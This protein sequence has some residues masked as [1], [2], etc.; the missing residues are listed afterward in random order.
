MNKKQLFKIILILLIIIFLLTIF[1]INISSRKSSK[2]YLKYITSDE[3]DENTTSPKMIHYVLSAY[4]GVVNPKALSKSTYYIINQKI[5]EYLKYCK[6]NKDI[7]KYFEKNEND[8]YLDLGIDDKEQF[9]KFMDEINKLS[10]DLKY[11]SSRF[12]K[13]YTSIESDYTE[14]VIHIKYENQEEISLDMIIKNY[15][16]QDEPV[17]VYFKK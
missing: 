8:I 12:D 17:I 11:E 7:D 10:G 6:T 4:K 15:S 1:L 5:P 2:Q 3:I 14:T 13:E 16:E 9:E